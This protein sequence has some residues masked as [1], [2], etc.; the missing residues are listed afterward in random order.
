MADG[1][2]NP[3]DFLSLVA[4]QSAAQ[5]NPTQSGINR[6][7]MPEIGVLTGTFYGDTGGVS[8][9]QEAATMLQLAPDILRISNIAQSNP[10]DIRAQIARKIVYEKQ[11]VWEVKRLIQKYVLDASAA[12]EDIDT[13]ATS[14]ELMA[15]ADKIQNQ[16]DA[17]DASYAKASITKGNDVFSQAGLPSPQERFSPEQLLPEFFA[18]YAT[19]T[20]E[21]QSK[22]DALKRNQSARSAAV[23][24]LGDQS[25]TVDV[26]LAKLPEYGAPGYFDSDR[27]S[28]EG[29]R[30]M[31]KQVELLQSDYQ[32]ALA[33]LNRVTKSY[34]PLSK[35]SI[36]QQQA[37]SDAQKSLDAARERFDKKFALAQKMGMYSPAKMAETGVQ[38]V[39][40]IRFK[41]IAG[42]AAARPD[43]SA[44]RLDLVKRQ[45]Y[46]DDVAAAVARKISEQSA[47]IGYTP[48]I[49]A[50]MTRANFVGLGGS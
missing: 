31:S 14:T 34:K 15:F 28:Q 7:F 12:G 22:L 8:Q 19:G 3:Y 2:I 20:Q 18:K 40:T 49:Q 25:G 4:A 44:E 6:L 1:Q 27:T 5:K 41:E 38:D 43:T 32:K 23:K 11:P 42:R 24:F 13:A 35:G 10:D 48:L 37:I 29:R 46:E 9:Q 26:R 39:E 47:S 30:T 16:S 21:R 17:L 36:S 45:K 50:L 33:Y